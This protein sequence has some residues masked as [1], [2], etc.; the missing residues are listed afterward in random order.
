MA[1]RQLD[2]VGLGRPH[3]V[4]DLPRRRRGT[5]AGVDNIDVVGA[6]VY[7]AAGKAAR[8][9]VATIDDSGKFAIV[10]TGDTAEGAR[11][12][13]ADDHGNVFVADAQGARLFVF[14]PATTR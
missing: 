8:L 11:N 1:G 7:V 13:V 14:A 12:A 4:G 5:G 6:T 2:A 9:T 10:A 3:L